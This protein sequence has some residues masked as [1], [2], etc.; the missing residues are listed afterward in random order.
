[1]F[2]GARIAVKYPRR[3]DAIV[4]DTPISSVTSFWLPVRS[5]MPSRIGPA[6][7]SAAAMKDTPAVFDKFSRSCTYRT[8]Q[9][10]RRHGEQAKLELDVTAGVRHRADEALIELDDAIETG[11]LDVLQR[12]RRR[13][14]IEL[15]AAARSM[16]QAGVTVH[17]AV[18]GLEPLADVDDARRLEEDVQVAGVRIEEA[19]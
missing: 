6:N 14:D 17:G 4:V 11:S 18:E 13:N 9:V 7:G 10:A 12:L 16:R 19:G 3:G 15:G 5:F 2:F 8:G 1:M